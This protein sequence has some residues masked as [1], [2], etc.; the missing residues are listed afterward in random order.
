[1]GQFQVVDYVA[2]RLTQLAVLGLD[3]DFD[4]IRHDL[5][6]LRSRLFF[7]RRLL[8]ALEMLDLL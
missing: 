8:H 2:K 6:L 5:F 4:D 1:M 3:L 7:L